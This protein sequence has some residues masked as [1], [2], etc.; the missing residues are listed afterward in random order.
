MWNGFLSS[1]NFNLCSP[2]HS[3]TPLNKSNNQCQPPFMPWLYIFTNYYYIPTFTFN[4]TNS[5]LFELLFLQ[6][7]N[8]FLVTHILKTFNVLNCS[9]SLS[10]IVFFKIYP[11]AIAKFSLRIFKCRRYNKQFSINTSDTSSS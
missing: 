4:C 5:N 7:G 8:M 3:I 10:Q 1:T 11:I 9:F 6:V 2:D